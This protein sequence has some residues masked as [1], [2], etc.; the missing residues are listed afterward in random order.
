MYTVGEMARLVGISTST[1]RYYDKEGLLP[2]VE[3]SAGG[4]R[5]FKESD[6]QC[7][8]IIECLKKTGMSLKDIKEFIYMAM[9]GDESIDERLE[10]FKEQRKAVL[11]QMEELNKTLETIDFKCWY[12]ETAKKAG[13][14]SVFENMTYDDIPERFR[15][16]GHKLLNLK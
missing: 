15:E 11:E 7:L 5:I 6:Y 8:Q 13:T 4:I 9:Q 12:Y 14:E 16:Q 3:R 2:F 10:L 1:L